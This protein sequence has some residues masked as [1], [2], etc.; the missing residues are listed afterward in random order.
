MCDIFKTE[1]LQ[2]QPEGA[3]GCAHPRQANSEVT[4]FIIQKEKKKKGWSINQRNKF[5]AD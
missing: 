4:Q 5:G 3:H 1:T 2:N